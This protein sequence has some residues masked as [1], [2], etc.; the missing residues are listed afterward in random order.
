MANGKGQKKSLSEKF[1][2]MGPAAIVT[3]AFIGPGTITTTTIA[4]VNFRYEL[5]WAILFSGISLAFLM[6]MAGRIGIISDHDIVEATIASLPK[7]RAIELFIK[8]LVIITLFAVAFGFEAGNLIGGS[9]GLS[10]LLSIPQWV[11]ALILGG[12]ALYAVAIG[13]AKTLEKLM[14]LF[15]GLMGIVFVLT[16]VLV[17]PNYLDVLKG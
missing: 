6:E 3:S 7:S 4:G 1:K 12:A 2:N 16:M 10:D 8:G 14:S 15:V 5:L 9:L 17:G 13:T 11:S